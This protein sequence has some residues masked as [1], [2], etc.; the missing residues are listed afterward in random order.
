MVSGL[1]PQTD[2]VPAENQ[3]V[4]DLE[5]LKVLSDPLRLRIRELMAKPATVKQVAAKLDLPPTKLYYHI[6]L[7]EKHALIVLVDTRLVSGIV[8]KHYQI[9][10]YRLQ[11]AKQLLS[12]S[13][14]PEGEGL[15]LAINSIFESTRN[16]LWQSVR[17]RTMELDDEG[18]RHKS[19]S[20]HSGK[21]KLTEEQAIDFYQE[22]ND[23]F[24]RFGKLSHEQKDLPTAKTYRNLYVLFPM[25]SDDEDSE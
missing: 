23:L 3:I 17:D 13:E 18:E 19:I 15:S 20:I 11:L 22:L 4:D 2:F 10:S 5:T 25:K 16:D 9:S 6:N 14:D 1:Q 21:I 24:E 7:L 12:A 8:E